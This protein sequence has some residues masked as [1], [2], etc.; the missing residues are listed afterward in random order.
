MRRNIYRPTEAV[1]TNKSPTPVATVTIPSNT[2]SRILQPYNIRVANKPKT[3]LRHILTNVK[4]SDEANRQRAVY[5]IKLSDCQAFYITETGRNLN[6]R[7]TEHKQATRNG[8][9]N[10]HIAVPHQM[11]S[12]NIDCDSAHHTDPG[13]LVH[14]RRLLTDVNNCG[15]SLTSYQRRKRNGQTV[16]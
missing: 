16:F 12:N 5:K 6:P 1:A 4:V 14:N 11:T 7:L 15:H 10:N 13:K 2:I 9:A 3:I 8:D